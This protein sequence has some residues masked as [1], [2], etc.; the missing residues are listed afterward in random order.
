MF[1]VMVGS[2]DE[3][4]EAPFNIFSVLTSSYIHTQCHTERII[5]NYGQKRKRKEEKESKENMECKC[6]W[7]TKCK[8]SFVI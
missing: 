8:H 2:L 3:A 5:V 1:M 6:C 4:R 7:H